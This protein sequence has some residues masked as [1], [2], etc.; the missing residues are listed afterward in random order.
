M[1]AT[2]SYT[3]Q[4]E[5]AV[6]AVNFSSLPIYNITLESFEAAGRMFALFGH[7]AKLGA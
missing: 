3:W 4:V 7:A 6:V 1:A 2:C 5:L